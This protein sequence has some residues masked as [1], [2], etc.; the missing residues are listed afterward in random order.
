MTILKFSKEN[1]TDKISLLNKY[2]KLG[3]GGEWHVHLHVH[4]CGFGWYQGNA[5]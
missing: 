2:K 1:D 3:G 4:L 5:V